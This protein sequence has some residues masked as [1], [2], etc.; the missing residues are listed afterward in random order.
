MKWIVLC[1]VLQLSLPCHGA[2]ELPVGFMIM[3]E[4]MADRLVLAIA[5]AVAP[6]VKG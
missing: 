6:V 2:G 5:R 4:T 1:A 3:G